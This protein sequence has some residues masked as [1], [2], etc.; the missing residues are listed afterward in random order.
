MPLQI[1]TAS[2]A[3]LFTILLLFSSQRFVDG[4]LIAQSGAGS[5]AASIRRI[6]TS[7]LDRSVRDEQRRTSR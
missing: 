1:A 4:H 6:A 2:F 5:P 3:V 7:E